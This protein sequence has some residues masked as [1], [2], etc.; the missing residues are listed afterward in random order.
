MPAPASAAR[1]EPARPRGRGSAAP[2]STPAGWPPGDGG[3]GASPTARPGSCAAG[4]TRSRSRPSRWM[5]CSP[6]T[7]RPGRS[8]RSC[9]CT[10]CSAPAMTT[11]PSA[12]S[13]ACSSSPAA[14]GWSRTS[15]DY[16]R[17]A[18][19]LGFSPHVCSRS[20]ERV[21]VR[22]LIQTGRPLHDLTVADLHDAE[23]AFRARGERRNGD[24][25]N[26]RGFLHAAWTVLFHLG[27]L[28]VTPPNRR[29]R[30]HA[31]HAHHF[32]GVPAW[33][34]A[35]LEDYTS[36]ISGTHEPS[37]MDGIAI[38]LAAL[39]PA[40]G[41]R[42]P[43]W[44]PS[45]GW[46]GSVTS[47]PTSPRPPPPRHPAAGSPSSAGDQ[48]SRIIT[49]GR[50]LADITE[51]EWPDAPARRLMFTR[52]IPKLPQPLPRYLPADAD[53]LIGE[54]LRGLPEPAVRRRAAAHPRHRAAHRR[55]ARPRTRLRPRDPRH[56]RLAESPARQARQRAHGP[57]RR[58]DRRPDRP[59]RRDP[60]PRPAAAAPH[61][62]AARRVP[63]GPLQGSALGPGAARRTRPR[64]PG[65]RAAHGHTAPCATPTPPPWSTPAARCRR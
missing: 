54:A 58:R 49:L 41:R 14:P 35:R 19:E 26:D 30:E 25:S 62:P 38:R 60:H 11:W 24:W 65:R 50:F 64:L 27:I 6:R 4:P 3:T 10:T 32:G 59:H 36:A 28:D 20:A 23:A 46:T 63:A 56:R 9:C 43:A 51:W 5:P 44:S 22:L 31:G 34:A 48:R 42:R 39:R 1:A 61:A 40:P 18:A 12:S 37:T 52:D 16:Q 21:I 47:R 15:T 57:P 8:S 17:A 29:R 2:P 53:R 13:P 33:L 55:A 45:P 7:S